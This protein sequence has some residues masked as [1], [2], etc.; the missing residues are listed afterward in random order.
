MQS[1]DTIFYEGAYFLPNI[2]CL[3]KFHQN[4]INLYRLLQAFFTLMYQY[5]AN[6]KESAFIQKSQ[7][8][9]V[10]ILYIGSLIQDIA[11]ILWAT[12]FGPSFIPKGSILMIQIC[13]PHVR[14]SISLLIRLSVR[15]YVSQRPLI[16]LFNSL[17]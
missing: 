8:F 14:L 12:H 2:N 7:D 9:T 10:F 15:L 3:H 11:L 1:L 17:N 5:L 16:I 13:R 4:I 6:V